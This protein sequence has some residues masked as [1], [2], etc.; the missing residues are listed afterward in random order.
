[1]SRSGKSAQQSRSSSR[2]VNLKRQKLK[3]DKRQKTS[4]S[5][6]RARRRRRRPHGGSGSSSDSSSSSS[7]SGKRKKFE[8][9]EGHMD[10]RAGRQAGKNATKLSSGP[11]RRKA[12]HEKKAPALDDKAQSYVHDKAA[13]VRQ[14]RYG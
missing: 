2:A 14:V 1:M 7:S 8:F 6:A 3:K 13:A 9:I 5:A 10:W 4:S 12:G 11:D